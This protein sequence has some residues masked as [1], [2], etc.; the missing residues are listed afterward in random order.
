MTVPTAP[1]LQVTSGHV[2]VKT[3]PGLE[4]APFGHLSSGDILGP[5][6]WKFRGSPGEGRHWDGMEVEMGPSIWGSMMILSGYI[7][8]LLATYGGFHSHGGTRWWGTLG[9]ISRACLDH[10]S[11]EFLKE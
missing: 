11:S 8:V 7:L 6:S 9:S 2:R 10:K 3:P 4:L 1:L 5:G